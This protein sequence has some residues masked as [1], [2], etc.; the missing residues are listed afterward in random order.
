LFFSVLLAALRTPALPP[1]TRRDPKGRCRVPFRTGGHPRTRVD[2]PF[3]E[4][5]Q[6][7]AGVDDLA[8]GVLHPPAT[9]VHPPASVLHPP[10]AVQE[11]H[12][13]VRES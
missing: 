1:A 9:V 11:P 2:L 6:A 7:L 4:A 3:P 10:A 5:R 13:T 12:A 8:G